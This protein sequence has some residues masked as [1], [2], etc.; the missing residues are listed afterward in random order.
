MNFFIV[1]IFLLSTTIYA[2][3]P[4]AF[5]TLAKSFEEDTQR[6]EAY[7]QEAYFSKHEKF[8]KEYEERVQQTFDLGFDL[9]RAIVNSGDTS[10]LKQKYLSA[11]RKLKND[12]SAL[13]RIYVNA[14][15][16]SIKNDDIKLFSYLI[17]HPMRPLQNEHIR[18]RAL[19]YYETKRS[20][21]KIME[22]EQLRQ[23][24]KF[25]AYSRQIAYEEQ[26]AYQEHIKVL[27]AAQA[28]KIRQSGV[29][30]KRN[31]VL[32]ST[33]NI[34]NAVEFYAENLNAYDVTLTL[35]LKNLKN[36]IPSRKLPLYVELHAHAKETIIQLKQENSSLKA[37]YESTYGWVM[38]VASA[39][40]DNSYL[41]GI[42][43]KKGTSVRVSQGFNGTTSHKGYSRYAV[44]FAVPTGTAVYAAR[45]GKVVST[46]STGNKGGFIKGYGRYA[47]F[48]V[49]EHSDKTFGKYYHLKKGGVLV[50]VGDT[51]NRGNLIGYSGNTGYS[52]GPHLHFSVSKVDPKYRQRP[53]T[54]PFKFQSTNNGVI[55]EPRR[56]DVYVR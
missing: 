47:N 34:G 27:T 46:K 26:Q 25:D 35:K 11:L 38:G 9:D 49:I 37:Y 8:F 24:K 18:N 48:I 3:H 17:Q 2:T 55:T 21:V 41:Y 31:S 22:A 40:H 19:S 29:R 16:D 20:S 12:Q 39:E 14:L 52:S 43:F 6:I 45:G 4:E 23:E 54:L 36:F 30:Q 10:V 53:I 32:V 13:D 5:S 1:V 56:G 44:D 50:K 42:P 51:I 15:N 33:K 7:K 28:N